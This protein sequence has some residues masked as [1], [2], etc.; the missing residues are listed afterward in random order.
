MGGALPSFLLSY[1]EFILAAACFLAFA[2]IRRA[3]DARRRAAPVPVSWPV[4]GMLPFVVA[5]LGRLLDA[6]AAAL[7]EL[8]CTFMFRGPWLVGADFLVT[9][10]P[11]VF[12]H[13][14]VANFAGYDKGRDFAE[15]F[16]V[17]GD[18][19]LV[20][21][22]ASWAAKRH[23]AASVFTSAAFRG[24]VLSTV[25]RQ[26]RRLLVP[27]LDHAGGVVEL[28]DVFMRYSLDVSYTVAFAADLDSLSVASAAE[29][30]PPFG[31]ATRVTGEAVLLRHIAPA[32]WWKLMRWLNV[33]VERR[34]ADA[35]AVLDEFIYREIANRRSRPAPAVA[36]GDDLLCMYMASPIDPAMSDQTLRD[37][38]V[39]FMFAAKDLIAAALTWLF[40]MICT[41]PHVEAKILDELRS[42][43]TTT[44]AGAV[45][46]DADELRAATYLH[47]AVLETLR[48]YPSAPFEEKEAVGDDVLPGGTAVRKGTRVVFCLYAMGRV[49]GIWGSDCREF[50]PERWLSTGDGDGGAGKVRQE[51]SYKFAAFNAGPRSCLGKDLG[52]SNI[53][54]AAAAIV[55]NF[56]VELVAGHVVE[57][58]DSVVLHTKNGLMVRVK[59][60]ET[61]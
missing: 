35:K 20:A 15:M 7:P 41:H 9:C 42:L 31:E 39:G 10:D 49:E 30:F 36:G 37:A 11:A 55:Y 16:D 29:P 59:R 53:K 57:P 13:C 38:A 56:T 34:L 51:P 17:V 6:A 48:L 50:R 58:K 8:G 61:A 27:F 43:H 26:T 5:H 32:G 44:T 52:L 18:G 22:A 4:V 60:R 21:D 14:L 46:F 28:E 24:F 1:P 2:A 33:G 54:I 45:V 19:L 40:Y 23:L 25:E 3:R 12:R 47:A